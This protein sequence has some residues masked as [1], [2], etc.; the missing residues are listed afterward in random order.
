MF[1]HKRLLRSNDKGKNLKKKTEKYIENQRPTA[2]A[3]VGVPFILNYIMI[4]LHY[5]IAPIETRR[6]QTRGYLD[7]LRAFK[8]VPT[9]AVF[10]QE[11]FFI[12]ML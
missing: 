4:F 2:L 7:N 11:T 5:G 6:M 8:R 3:P 10:F 1:L 12:K 9:H